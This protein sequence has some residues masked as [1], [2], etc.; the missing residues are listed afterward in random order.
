MVLEKVIK[1]KDLQAFKVHNQW[2]FF[3]EENRSEFEESK[4]GKH[5][6]A[7]EK[8]W[9]QAMHSTAKAGVLTWLNCARKKAG[10]KN[11]ID[12]MICQ[13]RKD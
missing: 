6:I 11:P 5:Y 9:L 1:Q 13:S 12:C 3:R 8:T 7:S 4:S 2:L 10:P